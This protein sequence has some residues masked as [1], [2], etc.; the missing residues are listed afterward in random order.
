[1]STGINTHL[2]A[3]VSFL[4]TPYLTGPEDPPPHF[5]LIIPFCLGLTTPCTPGW[6]LFRAAVVFPLL[7]VGW[8]HGIWTTIPPG[9]V[10]QWGASA[11]WLL[12]CIRSFL[13]FVG[14]PAEDYFFRVRPSGGS[15]QVKGQSEKGRFSNGDASTF[16]G[17]GQANGVGSVKDKPKHTA[18]SSQE[19]VPEPIPPP[20][21]LAKFG[22]AF[23]LFC[24][25]R[26]IGWNYTSPLP[27]S[28]HKHPFLR[29]SSRRDHL[30]NRIITFL[31][32]YL[33]F[34]AVR[35]YMNLGPARALAFFDSLPGVGPVYDELAMWEKAVY[36]VCVAVRIW[37]SIEWAALFA[38][39]VA[40]SVGGLMGWEGEMWSP[41]GWPPTF[42]SIL[43]VWE[44]PGLSNMWSRVSHNSA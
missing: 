44:H 32:G 39:I 11:F 23:S 24:S 19:L 26:G 15:F 18:P 16:K 3:L 37:W 10:R 31:V 42:G 35:T 2:P 9:N 25:H 8:N 1:M 34:D 28:A 27:P 30:L 29:T 17:N 40:V 20:W 5:L 12:S 7:F 22:W 6:K 36:S 33:V 43:D 21:T 14:F 41:W 13:Y 4:P 38:G